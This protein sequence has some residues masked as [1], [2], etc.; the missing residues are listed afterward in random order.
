VA[1]EPESARPA[2]LRRKVSA[3]F[4]G[5]GGG[6]RTHTSLEALGI[7]SPARLPVSPLRRGPIIPH[8][9]GI[10]G[11]PSLARR[12]HRPEGK[13]E[14]RVAVVGR[15]LASPIV[16]TGK[17]FWQGGGRRWTSGLRGGRQ[18][19]RARLEGKLPWPPTLLSMNRFPDGLRGRSLPWRRERWGQVGRRLCIPGS[20]PRFDRLVQADSPSYGEGWARPGCVV[21]LPG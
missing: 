3:R 13:R 20:P 11:R 9:G 15:A 10:S 12:D 4:L 8:L 14:G 2:A 7:L 18:S 16:G 21:G 5:A 19:H 17:A 6:N 1:A